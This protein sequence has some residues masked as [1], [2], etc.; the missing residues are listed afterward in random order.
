MLLIKFQ[1][2][3]FVFWIHST[4]H[5]SFLRCDIRTAYV[6]SNGSLCFCISIMVSTADLRMFYSTC[7]QAN[8][9]T[10]RI[11]ICWPLTNDY[12]MFY[13]CSAQSS[14]MEREGKTDVNMFGHLLRKAGG[15]GDFRDCPVS[16]SFIMRD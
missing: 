9:T 5:L 13:L 12:L 14:I 6:H 2:K 16:L 1:S 8:F 15:M 11:L 10:Y 3:T 4:E 7:F